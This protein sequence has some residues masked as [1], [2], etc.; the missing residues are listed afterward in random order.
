ML[1]KWAPPLE[2][3]VMATIVVT[4]NFNTFVG[5]TIICLGP[6]IGNIISFPLS[7]VLCDTMGWPW[8]FYL[9]GECINTKKSKVSYCPRFHW[10]FL[11]CGLAVSRI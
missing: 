10:S 2:R 4:G 11:V 9:F 5:S 7:G 3:S 1:G 8:V 6:N